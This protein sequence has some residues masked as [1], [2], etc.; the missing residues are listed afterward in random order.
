MNYLVRFNGITNVVIQNSIVNLFFFSILVYNQFNTIIV[1]IHNT[2]IEFILKAII[3]NN[4]QTTTT[5]IF[6]IENKR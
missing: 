3:N 6:K 5:V 1:G 2:K 4:N